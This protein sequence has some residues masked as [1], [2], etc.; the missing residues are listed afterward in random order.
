[1]IDGPPAIIEIQKAPE[2]HNIREELIEHVA[3]L[4]CRADNRDPDVDTRVSG[5]TFNTVYLPYP[6]N[7]TWYGYRERAESTIRDIFSA[8]ASAKPE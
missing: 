3:R 8:A 5:S 4:L 1:M 7:L 6:T 2:R